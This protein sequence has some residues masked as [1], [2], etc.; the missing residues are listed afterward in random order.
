MNYR[1]QGQLAELCAGEGLL[2]QAVV[3]AALLRFLMQQEESI[4]YVSAL[5]GCYNTVIARRD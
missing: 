2:S 4:G 3:V 5:Y 1:E